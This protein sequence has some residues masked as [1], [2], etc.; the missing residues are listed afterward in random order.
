MDAVQPTKFSN[1]IPGRGTSGG[2]LFA[3]FYMQYGRNTVTF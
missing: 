3:R 2:S 1:P